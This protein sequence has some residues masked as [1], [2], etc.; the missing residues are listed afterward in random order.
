MNRSISK[1]YISIIFNAN[2]GVICIIPPP[3]VGEWRNTVLK[4][5]YWLINGL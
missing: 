4:F 2:R 3:L 5:P 1:V